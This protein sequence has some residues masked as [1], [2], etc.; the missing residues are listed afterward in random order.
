ME[1]SLTECDQADWFFIGNTE[2]A[3]TQTL[4]SLPDPVSLASAATQTFQDLP[5]QPVP[6]RIGYVVAGAA[7]LGLGLAAG[8]FL[9]ARAPEGPPPQ[10]LVSAEGQQTQKL[11]GEPIT[12]SEPLPV[13]LKDT[14]D[15]SPMVLQDW[16]EAATPS[17]P[18]LESSL[19][20]A[21]SPSLG[22]FACDVPPATT[23]C[24]PA[25]KDLNAAEIAPVP[26]SVLTQVAGKQAS[27][28]NL[29]GAAVIGLGLTAFAAAGFL[30]RPLWCKGANMRQLCAARQASSAQHE[31][32]QGS[33]PTMSAPK[34]TGQAG[35]N[36]TVGNVNGASKAQHLPSF[37]TPCIPSNTKSHGMMQDAS[38]CVDIDFAILAKSRP[39]PAATQ[40]AE[41]Y[42]LD[43][44]VRPVPPTSSRVFR[45][46]PKQ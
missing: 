35:K 31:R 30:S 32:L 44:I 1:G 43:G 8:R 27:R 26:D 45:M 41:V 20:S 14:K 29:Q 23:S 42:I 5:E 25:D 28:Y 16:G 37:A 24:E 3:S 13:S 19:E 22:A 6:S 17:L 9:A 39:R 12:S 2:E 46:L 15:G 7:L 40:Q 34:P 38:D 4:P 21:L 11:E 36:N 10:A 18:A 33:L